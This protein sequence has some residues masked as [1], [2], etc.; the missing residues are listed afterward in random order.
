MNIKNIFAN[1]K[2]KRTRQLAALGVALVLGSAVAFSAVS[3]A[4]DGDPAKHF[5]KRIEHMQK[6]LALTDQ[7]VTQ[8]RGIFEQNKAKLEA[9]HA[10]VKAATDANKPAAKAQFRA[11]REAMEAQMNALLTPDQQAKVTAWKAK[12][13]DKEDKEKDGDKKD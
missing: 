4:H 2:L 9:D 5:E 6:K 7:Q 3:Y 12:H 13:K 8:M 1:F 11:D 10:A